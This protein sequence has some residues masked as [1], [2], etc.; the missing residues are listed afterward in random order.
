MHCP[1]IAAAGLAALIA[2]GLLPSGAARADEWQLKIEDAQADIRVYY[3]THESGFTE[4]RAVTHVRSQLSGLVALFRD[5]DTMP[6][7]VYR[8]RKAA[9]LT[10]ISDTEVYAYTVSEMQWP[11]KDRDAVVHTTLSQDPETLAV[12]I[13]G[14]GVPG[15]IPEN[16]AYVRMRAVESFWRFTPS[17]S[18]MVEVVF[19]GHGDPG[20]NLSSGLLQWVTRLVLWEA[21]FYTLLGLQKV[22]FR[23]A[24]QAGSFDFIREPAP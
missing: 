21:P 13:R 12:T 22:V 19:Q 2:A 8:N 1:N 15:H 24:Y 20:G 18:G 23:D 5:V 17:G 6:E 7:W 10:R 3:R 11:L 9:T 14:R 4:F 16:E